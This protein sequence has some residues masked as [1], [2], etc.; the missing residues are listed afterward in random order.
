[1]ASHTM[2][3]AEANGAKID[4]NGALAE[5]YEDLLAENGTTFEENV[6][7]NFESNGDN[8]MEGPKIANSIIDLIGRTPMVRL[9]RMARENGCFADIVLKLESMEP[10]SSVKDR[11]AMSMILEAERKG[12]IVPGES[13]LIEPTS[14]NTGIG[15][16]MV[17]AARGY[18]L[19]LT[20]PVSMSLERKVMLKAMVRS[21]YL[22]PLVLH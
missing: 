6:A 19:I 5:A 15:L 22:L 7:P 3:I 11:I 13:T 4:E 8:I 10:S 2:H 12:L 18:K 9:G 20:M 14:G 21:L 17:A 16:A 1:M